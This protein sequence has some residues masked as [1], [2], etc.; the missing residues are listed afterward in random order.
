VLSL[1]YVIC[2]VAKN[3]SRSADI[4]LTCHVAHYIPVNVDGA[5][6]NCQYVNA[7]MKLSTLVQKQSRGITTPSDELLD[8]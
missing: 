5:C 8:N 6:G 3:P 1:K 2:D 7:G 4:V